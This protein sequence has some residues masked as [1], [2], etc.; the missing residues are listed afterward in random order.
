[1]RQLL[2]LILLILTTNLFGQVNNRIST[3]EFYST[4]EKRRDIYFTNE[5]KKVAETYYSK[6]SHK[7]IG[8]IEYDSTN[9]KKI[10]TVFG[11]DA[12]EKKI[13]H[14]DFEKGFYKDFFHYMNLKFKDNFIFDGIQNDKIISVEYKNGLKDGALEQRQ[15][16]FYES[17]NKTTSIKSFV[18]HPTENML[19]SS[20]SVAGKVELKM[21]FKNDLV[22]G[23]Q[24]LNRN[25]NNWGFNSIFEKGK[26][27]SYNSFTFDK[28]QNQKAVSVIKS[29]YGVIN[30]NQIFNGSLWNADGNYIFW[31]KSLY[32]IGDIVF[33]YKHEYDDNYK[34]QEK[35]GAYTKDIDWDFKNNIDSEKIEIENF[36]QLRRLIGIPEFRILKY[37]ADDLDENSIVKIKLDNCKFDTTTKTILLDTVKLSNGYNYFDAPFKN[38]PNYFD[39][40]QLTKEQEINNFDDLIFWLNKNYNLIFNFFQFRPYETCNLS[41]TDKNLEIAQVLEKIINRKSGLFPNC[42]SFGKFINS[43][44]EVSSN[45]LFFNS[46]G[47]RIEI[48]FRYFDDE[49]G[50]NL[51]RTSPD[52]TLIC[53]VTTHTSKDFLIY[54]YGKLVH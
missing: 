40:S 45:L 42:P 51:S 11:Y 7:K 47:N 18:N 3:S 15:F 28:A 27:V 24:L 16:S 8:T 49:F 43:F 37:S 54:E 21:H 17:Y 22:D 9:D 41:T 12:D 46:N 52:F 6:E 36:D 25:A 50:F 35:F 34:N 33:S 10:K 13:L 26:V 44:Y 32:R 38:I 29:K 39:A 19:S 1:M 53:K 14:V 31:F 2:L 30:S 4:G 48:R 5:L 20:S 23:E